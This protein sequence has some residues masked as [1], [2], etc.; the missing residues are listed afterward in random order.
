MY[1]TAQTWN[2]TERSLAPTMIRPPN[3]P[4]HSVVAIPTTDHL[5]A[6]PTTDHLVAIPTTDHLVAIPTTDHLVAIPTTL[7]PYRLLNP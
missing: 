1:I 4:A 7:P 5:V 3:H 6:I 2:Y